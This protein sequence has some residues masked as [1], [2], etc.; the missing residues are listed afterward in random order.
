M[1]ERAKAP[2]DVAALVVFRIA[3]GLLV[4]VS[5]ARFLAY[6]W[7]KSLFIEPR[8]HFSYFGFD[9]LPRPGA[10]G[11]NAIFCALIVLGLMVA[12]G[13]FYRFA[14]A[15]LFV[16][17]AWVQLFDVANYLNHYYLVCVLAL[18]LAVMPLHR[19][20]SLDVWRNPALK[21]D[22]FPAW[23]TWVL[24]AQVGT[25]YFF[26][27]MAKLNADW[28]LHAQPL[29]IWLSA[30]A[31]LL[32]FGVLQTRA[33]AFAAAW[34]GFLFDTT[35]PLFL[36]LKQTRR[37]FYVLVLG[38]HAATSVLF[39]IGMFPV[40]MVLAAL[41]FF[42]PSW[43][44]RLLRLEAWKP[45]PVAAT[46]A[47]TWL[48]PALATLVV[49]QAV[50][51][52]RALAFDGP[53]SW[54]EQGMRFSWRV[55][56]R[57]KNGA[58]SFRVKNPQTGREW[59]VEPAKYLT[60]LQ[61][62]ELSVQPDLILQLAHHIGDDFDARGL[63]PVQVFADAHVSWNGRGVARLVN[64]EVDLRAERDGLLPFHW[65][66]PAPEGAPIHLLSMW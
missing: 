13:L 23:C 62:R 58:V 56:S 7:V 43:P 38:F 51:P 19:A 3:F 21:V 50:F 9:W 8:F 60:R 29:N 46:R 41:V 47:Q 65:V 57:E 14:S 11:I 45:A 59:E 36:S 26:A 61:E 53:V 28:L 37:Y 34:G 2:T 4:S 16:V 1:I 12:A 54:H 40:I 64:P 25:V 66:E 39:P 22:A 18:L 30:R 52:L 6:G 44:R 35:A 42:D 32:P 17:F 55:M 5:A 49:V 10:D 48:L 63:G 27:G 31:E 24:R 33:A 20:F 15:A